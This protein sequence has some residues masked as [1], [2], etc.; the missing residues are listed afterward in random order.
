[1]PLP[2][3]LESR[4]ALLKA[5]ENTLRIGLQYDM[6]V[7]RLRENSGDLGYSYVDASSWQK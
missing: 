5:Q 7:L 2:V 4:K 3:F 6:E 1:V